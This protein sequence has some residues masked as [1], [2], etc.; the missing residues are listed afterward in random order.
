MKKN[1]ISPPFSIW[2]RALRSAAEGITFL[3]TARSIRTLWAWTRIARRSKSLGNYGLAQTS[4]SML[5]V[6]GSWPIPNDLFHSFGAIT[7]RFPNILYHI[8]SADKLQ[9]LIWPIFFFSTTLSTVAVAGPTP[10]DPV[11]A[12]QARIISSFGKAGGEA[13]LVDPCLWIHPNLTGYP[14]TKSGFKQSAGNNL[15]CSLLGSEILNHGCFSII[16][17]Q[18]EYGIYESI[19]K[20]TR[21]C[22]MVMD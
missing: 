15:A 1:K 6:A 10:P 4:P 22:K 13:I 18:I 20:N 7:P 14:P 21:D 16:P 19:T 9:K 12:S 2:L 11:S 8:R 17:A 5:F 3:L